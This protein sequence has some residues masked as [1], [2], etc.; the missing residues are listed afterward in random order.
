VW[1][2]SPA[3]WLHTLGINTDL[4]LLTFA[5]NNAKIFGKMLPALDIKEKTDNKESHIPNDFSRH[6]T[7]IL[8]WTVY[9]EWEAHE[10]KK[11]LRIKTK[12]RS[13]RSRIS[14]IVQW[15]LLQY[16]DIVV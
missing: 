10:P 4:L 16:S 7:Y 8:Y 1:F 5:R 12:G 13:L 3:C 15:E 9:G 14:L 2:P 11:N 6:R